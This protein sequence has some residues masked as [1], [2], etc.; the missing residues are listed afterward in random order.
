LTL[1]YLVGSNPSHGTLSGTAPNLTY[2]PNAGFHGTD[3]FTFTVSNGTNT[4]APATV[5]LTVAPGTPTANPQSVN[6]NENSFVNLT[7]TGSDPDVPALP[8]TFAIVVGQGPSSGTITNFNPTTGTLTYTPNANFFGHDSFQFTVSNGT[9]TSV[10]VTVSLTVQNVAA[11]VSGTVGVSWGTAGTATLQTA[12]DGLRLLA[13]GRSIDLPWLGIDQLA[14][15]LSQ[16]ETLAAGDVSVTGINIAN[17][18]PVTISGSGT[19]YTITF[20]QPINAADRVTVTIGNASI[21]TFTRRLDVLPG[22]FNDDGSVTQQDA[23]LIRNEYLA[24]GGAPVTIFGD[25]DGNGVVDVND[26]NAVRRLIGTH[27]P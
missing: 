4:S 11:T 1:T 14:I 19:S 27:L 13:S 18:G 2:T 15:T 7:L 10:P 12:G 9:N 21:A 26:Y 23:L 25:I 24:I 22:D 5:S 16:P 8:L 20:A 3:S 6:L 17:Y